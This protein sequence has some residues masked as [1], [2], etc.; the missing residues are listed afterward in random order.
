MSEKNFLNLII[1]EGIIL[2]TLGICMLM[3]PKISSITF[4]LI[5]CIGFCVYGLY[6]IITSFINRKSSRHYILNI[7]LG[8]M[9]FIIGALLFFL[10]M[11]N[12]VLITAA[13]G[14]YFILESFSTISFAV[15]TRN[16]LYLW[17]M[18]L[19]VSIIQFILG[20][21]II[22]GL[23]STAFWVIG[24]LVGVNFLVSGGTLVSLGISNK[25]IYDV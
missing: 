20:F 21:T 2:T 6:R 19:L 10:P 9:L 18:S 17:W 8:V 25:Y 12:L 16:T 13:I 22:M 14:I 5:M 4:G 15:Q 7:L 23:P 24:V 1:L 3:L 11:F